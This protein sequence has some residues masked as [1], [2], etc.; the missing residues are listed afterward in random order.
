ML[1]L[2]LS[3]SMEKP[4][5]VVRIAILLKRQTESWNITRPFPNTKLKTPVCAPAV[6]VTAQSMNG[7]QKE[8]QNTQLKQC[9]Q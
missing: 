1:N 6:T 7:S 5:S 9:R 4:A 3:P 8:K 2:S